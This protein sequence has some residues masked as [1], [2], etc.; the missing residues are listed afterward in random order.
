[1]GLL[2]KMKKTAL[3]LLGLSAILWSKTWDSFTMLGNNDRYFFGNDSLEHLAADANR[4][5][6]YI[7]S[8][9]YCYGGLKHDMDYGMT[10]TVHY[11]TFEKT[12]FDYVTNDSIWIPKETFG[13]GASDSLKFWNGNFTKEDFEYIDILQDALLEISFNSNYSKFLYI[14]DS[15]LIH[16][17]VNLFIY[18]KYQSYNALC[19]CIYWGES[20]GSAIYCRYQDDESLNFSGGL[21]FERSLWK[22]IGYECDYDDY[23]CNDGSDSIYCYGSRINDNII[24]HRNLHI[25]NSCPYKVN[26]T[27][28]TKRASNVIIQKKKQPKLQLKGNH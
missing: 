28:A 5:G 6:I 7:Y 4:N 18:Q 9:R 23:R 1:M 16:F 2:I 25:D 24:I 11:N 10:K 12:P 20:F 8:V 27:A 21:S 13:K 22:E 15:T 26:G 3:L 19:Y 14:H 17:Y